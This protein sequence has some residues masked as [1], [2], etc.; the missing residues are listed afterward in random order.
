MTEIDYSQCEDLDK[1]KIPRIYEKVNTLH[2]ISVVLC[3]RKSTNK[4][5]EGMEANSTSFFSKTL[6][7]VATFFLLVEV[8]VVNN[9]HI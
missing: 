7:H 5:H 4:G 6:C 3:S 2:L 1:S 9:H 8:V